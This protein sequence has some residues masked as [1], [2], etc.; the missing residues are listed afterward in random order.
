MLFHV[1]MTVNLPLDMS[2]EHAA[3]LKADEKALAQ[4][5]Q[6]EGKWRHLWRIAGHY[7]NYSVFD[8][9]SVQDLHDLLMHLPLFPYMSIEVNA[10][11][12]HPSSIHEDDR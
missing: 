12:R 2:P 1:K 8:V 4:R 11:C 5:L 9:D 7:A 6:Q 3:N 10:L